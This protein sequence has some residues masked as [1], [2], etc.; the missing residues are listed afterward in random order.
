M[1]DLPTLGVCGNWECS[2]FG[3]VHTAFPSCP[4]RVRRGVGK[5]VRRVCGPPNVAVVSLACLLN[6]YVLKKTNIL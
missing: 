1:W 2:T 6:T 5:A 4:S 3:R